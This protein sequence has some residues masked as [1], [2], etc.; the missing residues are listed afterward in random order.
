MNTPSVWIVVKTSF[1]PS[2][3]GKD[4]KQILSV[5]DNPDA[6]YAN[7]D[8]LYENRTSPHVAYNVIERTLHGSFEVK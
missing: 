7:A 8:Y 6:A 5:Y 1:S 3:L 2:E 4:E